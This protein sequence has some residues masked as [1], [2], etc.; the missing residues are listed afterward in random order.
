MTLLWKVGSEVCKPALEWN[1][2]CMQQ[3]KYDVKPTDFFLSFPF[4]ELC[5]ALCSCGA[6]FIILCISNLA[7]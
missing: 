6:A 3:E 4:Q 5:L 2:A 1:N 7:N